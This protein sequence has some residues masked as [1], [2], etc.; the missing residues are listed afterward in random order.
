[1]R[2]LASVQ[3]L[4]S[5]RCPEVPDIPDPQA[6]FKSRAR[7]QRCLRN[8]KCR[9]W[10]AKPSRGR[11]S[12]WALSVDA[13]PRGGLELLSAC[14]SRTKERTRRPWSITSAATLGEARRHDVLSHAGVRLVR[15]RIAG[16]NQ[17]SRSAL[18]SR[19]SR[20]ST[21][22]LNQPSV[23]PTI[24]LN[25]EILPCLIQSRPRLV[26]ARNSSDFAP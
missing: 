18:A 5:L 2:P 12:S 23:S 1:M 24:R 22:L 9:L 25:S 19:R 15:R 3:V 11:G 13:P 8:L 26:A 10:A 14:H 6:R 16:Q 7:Y 4:R 21:P 20:R 17:E